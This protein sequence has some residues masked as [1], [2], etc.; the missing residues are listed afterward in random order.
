MS[1][2]NSIRVEADIADIVQKT[3]QLLGLNEAQVAALNKYI[4]TSVKWTQATDAQGNMMMALTAAIKAQI[5][6]TQRLDAQVRQTD[7][8]FELLNAQ[9]TQLST[10]E[11][12]AAKAAKLRTQADY[13]AEKAFK[14]RAKAIEEVLRAEKRAND[15]AAKAAAIRNQQSRVSVLDQ[16]VRGITC[17]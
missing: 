14:A 6:E 2:T 15:L 16:T 4:Q 17:G 11:V 10:A 13:E 7:K 1:E 5:F 8:G 3:K 9:I 12:E